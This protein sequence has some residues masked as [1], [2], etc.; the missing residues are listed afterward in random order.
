M[1]LL[2]VAPFFGRVLH[3]PCS[4][5]LSGVRAETRLYLWSGALDREQA[6]LGLRRVLRAASG[7]G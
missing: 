2:S 4:P 1:R 3:R 5:V 6:D 7:Q